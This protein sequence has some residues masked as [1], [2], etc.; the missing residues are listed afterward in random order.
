MG[1]D[2]RHAQRVKQSLWRIVRGG[3]VLWVAL[4][5]LAGCKQQGL[6][7]GLRLPLGPALKPASF[8]HMAGWEM[9]N[10][11]EALE[12]YLHSC[13]A[14]MKLPD[15]MEIQPTQVGGK[16]RDW[17]YT[18]LLAQQVNRF[19]REQARQ[20]F[21]MHFNPYTVDDGSR[22]AAH[23]QGFFTG[24]Y[25]PQVAVSEYKT[26]EYA[27]PIYARPD[28]LVADKV[29]GDTVYGVK[30]DGVI[31]P[32]A[33][34]RE[35]ELGLVKDDL[36]VLAWAKDP[37]DVFFMQVQGSGQLVLPS[38][39]TFHV[40][41]DGKNGHPYHSIGK[42]LQQQGQIRK[43]DMSAYAIKDWLRKHPETA[44]D[45]MWSNPSYVFFRLLKDEGV[46]GAQAVP[47][48]P[49]R[50]MAVDRAFIPLSAPVW[51]ETDVPSVPG[52]AS[53]IFR[54]LLIAQDTGAAIKGAAR[55][56]IFWGGGD[57]AEAMAS[58]MQSR[59]RMWLLIPKSITPGF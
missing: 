17:K 44:Q 15:D 46:A 57:K 52:Q 41:F 56:D 28:R 42:M 3:G 26:P 37:I 32:Y 7:A 6:P 5:L 16:A 49:E 58:L 31:V 10:H 19:D 59:G 2:I 53:Q 14:L 40:G 20:F 21:E 13:E 22:K 11:A 51:V 9:D 47:L 12:A 24:Y 4:L 36:K 8:M 33:T 38:G 35:I 39:L 48:T 45:V 27:V 29:N 55:G 23:E 1:V 34:R 50:S 43:E 54:H 30:K 18:C 25:V